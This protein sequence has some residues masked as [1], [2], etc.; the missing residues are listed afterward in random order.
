TRSDRDWSSDV[1]SS[2]LAQLR[3]RGAVTSRGR[4]LPSEAVE[5][6]RRTAQELNLGQHLRP[7]APP[8]KCW[9]KKDLRLLGTM[10]DGDVAA[11]TEIGRASCRER[12]EDSVG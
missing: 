6:R 10:S 2:D 7:G 9:K 4:A 8:E 3:E 5:R 11:R 1:C 12:G